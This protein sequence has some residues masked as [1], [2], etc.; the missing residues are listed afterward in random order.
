MFF[1]KLRGSCPSLSLQRRPLR[2]AS[3][4]HG[5]PRPAAPHANLTV[6]GR[7]AGLP[8]YA[9]VRTKRGRRQASSLFQACRLS[10]FRKWFPRRLFLFRDGRPGLVRVEAVYFYRRFERVRAEVFLVDHAVVAHHEGLHPRD[11]V[12]RRRGDEREAADHHALQDEVHLAERRGLPLPLEHLEVVAVEGLILARVAL[13]KSARERLADDPA[14]RA[15]G[16]LP[17]QAV[18]RARRADDVL[19]VLVNIVALARLERVLVLRLDVAAADGYGVKLVAAHAPVDDLLPARVRVEEPL[20]SLPDD[21]HG[22]RPVVFA[23]LQHC[24]AWVSG[25]ER[26]VL[27]HAR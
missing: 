11:A 13:L 6:R 26:Y 4:S 21:G 14:P 1:P 16:V 25:I 2:S 17:R 10:F 22:E 9:S 3:G 5:D 23:Y 27:L 18:L 19:R 20:P 24:A 8:R 7:R 15:V 12:L